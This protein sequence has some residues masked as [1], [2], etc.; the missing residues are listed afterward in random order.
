MTREQAFNRIQIL[1]DELERHNYL[2]YVLTTPAIS[3]YEF[4]SLL[5]ELERLE[6]EFPEFYDSNSPTQR[7]GNDINIEFRQIEH[8]YPMLSLGNTYNMDELRD[9]DARVKKILNEPYQYVCELKYDGIAISLNYQDGKLKHAITRGDG[10]KGDD[11]TA[12]ARTI[13]SI[14]LKL[15][16][17]GFPS[18][19][20]IRGEI[21]MPLKIFNHLNEEK[22][23]NGE[24]LLANPRNA[25]A[26]AL[27]LQNSSQVAKRYLDCVL[28]YLMGDTL[29]SDSHYENLQTARKWGFKI[30]EYI[31]RYQNIDQI[32]EFITHWETER[33]NL[34]FDIDG[35]VIKVDSLKQQRKLGF[36]S[37]TPRWAISYKFPAERAETRLLSVD[38]QIG[39]TGAVT[40]VANL[41]PVQLAGTTVQRASLHNA[42]QIE[43]LDLHYDDYLVVEKAGEIIPQIV[44]VHKDNRPHD[45]QKVQFIKQCPEC[46]TVLI[47]REGEAAYYCPNENGCP[48]QIKG[49][50]E[51]FI[52][53][54]AMNIDS[55]GEGK[56]EILYDKGLVRNA[57]DLYDLTFEVLLG[58]EKIIQ[59]DDNDKPRKISF[60]EKTVQNI[61]KGIEQ[62]T[63]VPFERLLYA[64]GIRNVGETVARK[65]AVSFKNI[66][67]LKAATVDDLKNVSEIGEIIA[68][69]VTDYFQN[70]KNQAIIDRLRAKGLQMN[71]AEELFKPVSS[72]LEG[73]SIVV[74]G[75]FSTPQR[76]KELEQLVELH[77]GKKVDSVSA[78]TA[79]VIA[80]DKMGPGKRLKAQELNIPVIS[81]NDF[82]K[83]IE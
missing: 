58:I 43:S 68:K 59:T 19:F 35:I 38:F 66:D 55:L 47:R 77:G 57:A 56:V 21:F 3:D 26:G 82:L 4:D 80:G 69:S 2:Y 50:I 27:K 49:K 25:A 72:I 53:R 83:M 18:Q 33:K 52:S 51:H 76:R 54:N 5:K 62:S 64:L 67:N 79:F 9:F 7:V 6:K 45:S 1:R 24:P 44:G 74:S 78:S 29:P 48:P 40:P 41:F 28:Y 75:S 16:G 34:P 17:A 61:L 15:H 71:V 73:K 20:E 23:K 63:Q 42:G 39:R 32:F 22:K 10:S 70:D 37:K 31:K 36:T 14:P 8:K 46:N 12:N 81:E 60:R 30:S 13:R 65:L 11:V